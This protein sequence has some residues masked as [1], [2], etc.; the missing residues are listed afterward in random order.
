MSTAW[1][2]A[3]PYAAQRP[4]VLAGTPLAAAQLLARDRYGVELVSSHYEADRL[5]FEARR[6]KGCGSICVGRFEIERV[7]NG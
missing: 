1:R 4:I 6:P 5:V 7:V 3:N 2:I